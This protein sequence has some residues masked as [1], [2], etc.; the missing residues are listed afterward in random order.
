MVPRSWAAAV[1]NL[2]NVEAALEVGNEW[3]LNEFLR[4]MLERAYI[5]V[6]GFI[7][8]IL[9]R[10]QREKMKAVEKNS[11][12]LCCKASI[13]VKSSW[14]GV[15]RN[16]DHSGQSDEVSVQNEDVLGQWRKGHLCYKVAKNLA[17]LC[18]CSRVSWGV[19]LASNC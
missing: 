16:I 19:K 1:T 11:V 9:V 6:N 18:L 17:E 15:G 7:K 13:E 5:E 2:K 12:F 14:T 4:C 3:R 10:V 8:S